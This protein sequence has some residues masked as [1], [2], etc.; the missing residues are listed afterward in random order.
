MVMGVAWAEEA[1]RL[2][3]EGMSYAKI[4]AVVGVSK[5]RVQQVIQPKEIREHYLECQRIKDN[6][7]WAKRCAA[8]LCGR[9]GHTRDR[10]GSLCLRCCES[11]RH[12]SG[13]HG[14]DS[15]R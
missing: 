11:D 4:G 13:K 12:R 3:S 10:D 7:R 15:G 14:S 9:C 8:G 1:T 2:R 6:R 5:Q